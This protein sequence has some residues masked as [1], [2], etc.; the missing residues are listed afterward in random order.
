MAITNE[1]RVRAAKMAQAL[2]MGQTM[3]VIQDGG[4]AEKVSVTAFYEYLMLHHNCQCCH[5][6]S[7]R[8]TEISENIIF[9]MSS[10]MNS[11]GK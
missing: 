2:N 4:S 11:S 10:A 9:M 3:V 8:A 6:S 5:G 1:G 7:A